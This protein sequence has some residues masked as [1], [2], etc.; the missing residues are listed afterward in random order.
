MGFLIEVSTGED[1]R[2]WLRSQDDGTVEFCRMTDFKDKETG[3]IKTMPVPYK[4]YPSIDSALD[5]L[6][7]MRVNS[8]NASTLQELLQ[9]VREE[10]EEL[11]LLFSR[12][13]SSQQ[14]P[15]SKKPEIEDKPRSR[16]TKGGRR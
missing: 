14:P 16:R 7:R 6:F 5:R 2:L 4:F 11:R 8:R 15:K 13:T 3:K 9:N 12:E 1:G 10:R